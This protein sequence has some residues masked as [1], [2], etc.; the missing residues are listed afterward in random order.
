MTTCHGVSITWWDV[1]LGSVTTPFTRWCWSAARTRSIR[2][3]SIA[4]LLGILSLPTLESIHITEPLIK[5]L[6]EVALLWPISFP[7]A[8]NGNFQPYHMDFLLQKNCWS[9]PI[10][11]YLDTSRSEPWRF[12]PWASLSDVVLWYSAFLLQS[13]KLDNIASSHSCIAPYHIPHECT[14]A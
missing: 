5:S 13:I 8:L 11:S 3:P 6:H 2:L 1:Y 4:M 10:K 9:D 14:I 12:L 7:W